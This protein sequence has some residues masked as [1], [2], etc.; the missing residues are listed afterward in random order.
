MFQLNED[1]K[2]LLQEVVYQIGSQKEN[3]ENQKN[4]LNLEVISDLV[5]KFR[6]KEK[7]QKDGTKQTPIKRHLEP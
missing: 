2:E 6:L 5:K 4:S 3:Q 1:V 7:G